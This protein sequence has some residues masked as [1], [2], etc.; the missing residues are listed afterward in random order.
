MFYVRYRYASCSRNL[1]RLAGIARSP[2]YSQLTSTIHGL[3]V[4][5]SYRAENTSSNEF[6][7]HLDDSMRVAYLSATLNRWAGM[8]FDL[9]AVLFTALVI[10][11]AVIARLTHQQFSTVDIA[12]TLIYSI[13][14]MNV[15]NATIRL[16]LKSEVNRHDWI[17]TLSILDTQWRSKHK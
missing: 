9:V 12:L 3:Q 10:I 1:K 11:L 5:R 4:I 15:F 6:F 8:R 16:D 13:N 7:H 17:G 2:L 14:L